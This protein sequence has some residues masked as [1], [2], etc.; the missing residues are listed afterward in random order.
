MRQPVELGL[1]DTLARWHFDQDV[2]GAVSGS[3]RILAY[4]TKGEKDLWELPFSDLHLKRLDPTYVYVDGYLNHRAENTTVDPRLMSR[5]MVADAEVKPVGKFTRDTIDHIL[6]IPV[7]EIATSGIDLSNVSHS[8]ARRVIDVMRNQYTDGR[9]RETLQLAL[10][11]PHVQ[12][13]VR[14]AREESYRDPTD[15]IVTVADDHLGQELEAEY[16]TDVNLLVARALKRGVQELRSE[17]RKHAADHTEAWLTMHEEGLS[18]DSFPPEVTMD[19][20]ISY[21]SYLNPRPD[22]GTPVM[23]EIMYLAGGTGSRNHTIKYPD[24]SVYAVDYPTHGYGARPIRGKE[25]DGYRGNLDEGTVK[26]FVHVNE[27]WI[28]FEEAAARTVASELVREA[29][30]KG[31]SF[32]LNIAAYKDTLHAVAAFVDG[33]QLDDVGQEQIGA[34]KHQ[35][36]AVL[37]AAQCIE[38]TRTT[39]GNASSLY[40]YSIRGWGSKDD[41]HT[42]TGIALDFRGDLDKETEQA[43]NDFGTA[44]YGYELA[45]L[46]DAYA[47]HPELATH[48][49]QHR[50]GRKLTEEPEYYYD[51]MAEATKRLM[52]RD[53]VAELV[54]A[55]FNNLGGSPDQFLPA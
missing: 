28:N 14:M 41:V 8:Q 6:N 36:A 37:I 31:S 7:A 13:F 15:N 54:G 29:M 11:V 30:N 51:L 46:A 33:Q 1:P 25:E 18:L 22:K 53:K 55:Y 23:S 38:R 5:A 19:D 27:D 21:P 39:V 52:G 24:G 3:G 43:F 10:A 47:G 9:W 40:E 2:T 16:R 26:G 42:E 32:K 50:S 49:A 20:I 17:G 35:V 44:L 4:G 12:N 48:I 34:I 45:L